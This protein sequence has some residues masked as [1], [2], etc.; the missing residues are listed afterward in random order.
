METKRYALLAFSLMM[1]L[2]LA[3]PVF[4]AGHN[5]DFQLSAD[6]LASCPVED[7]MITATLKNLGTETDTYR[8]SSDS[9]W[10]TIGNDVITLDGGQET[11]FAVWI[12]PRIDSDSGDYTITL[13]AT[14]DSDKS[15]SYKSSLDFVVMRCHG[16]EM[17]SSKD[18]IRSCVGETEQVDITLKNTGKTEETFY[19][20]SDMGTFES[21]TVSVGSGSKKEVTLSVPIV[22]T[23]GTVTVT[24]ESASSY[25]SDSIEISI[26]ADGACYGV[27]VLNMPSKVSICKGDTVEIEVNAK[28]TG[29][30]EDEYSLS[31]DIED[32]YFQVEDLTLDSKDTKSTDL[33]VSTESMDIGEKS[34]SITISSVNSADTATGKMIIE[35]CYSVDMTSDANDKS[36]CPGT[37]VSFDIEISNTGKKTDT[38]SIETSEGLVEDDQM[39]LEPGKSSTTKVIVDTS[40]DDDDKDVLV[41]AASERSSAS[42]EFSIMMEDEDVC[43][44]FSMESDKESI[45]AEELKGYLYTIDVKN[46]GKFESTYTASS[47]GPDW[48]TVDPEQF[49]L[50]P[51]NKASVYVYASPDFTTS[52]GVYELE[53]TIESNQG[54]TETKSLEFAFK[55]NDK[56]VPVTG[57]AAS[58]NDQDDQ[59][60]TDNKS[61]NP[62]KKGKDDAGLP[63]DIIGVVLIGLIIIILIIF[64]P[65]IMR[66]DDKDKEKKETKTEEAKVET[67]ADKKK[68]SKED[69][70]KD[71]KPKSAAKEDTDKKDKDKEKK[72][73]V[74]KKPQAKKKEKSKADKKKSSDN[75]KEKKEDKKKDVK[76]DR[77]DEIQEILDNI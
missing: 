65:D 58:S 36:T 77:K 34:Y 1:I 69:K 32:A 8:I 55:S 28:N 25:V 9:E 67:K 68:E 29:Y 5:A 51:G 41:T 16:I 57:N 63:M 12:K 19:L 50:A 42:K 74:E 44:R 30:K 37:A 18:T 54:M 59:D 4:G 60:T 6:S 46:E 14:P 31:T 40:K 56:V 20:G 53:V 17:A 33:I 38:F 35:D 45:F 70:K 3:Q 21:N 13:T 22:S 26:E 73:K 2:A 23:E 11:T 48:V 15:M 61:K 47:G 75:K 64:G 27:A 10:V 71:E 52:E 39:T 66:R 49:S 72:A 76:K 43:Y 62:G 24:A 7:T